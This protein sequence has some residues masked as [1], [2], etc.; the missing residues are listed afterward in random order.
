MLR[1]IRQKKNPIDEDVMQDDF[2]LLLPQLLYS[3]LSS[4]AITDDNEKINFNVDTMKSER[5]LWVVAKM[6]RRSALGRSGKY[7]KLLLS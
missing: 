7:L 6:K 4:R 5:A 1:D 2:T 3:T